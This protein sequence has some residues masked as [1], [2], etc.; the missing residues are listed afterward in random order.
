MRTGCVVWPAELWGTSHDSQQPNSLV[1]APCLECRWK[2]NLI[3]I[4]V[5][6]NHPYKLTTAR[7]RTLFNICLFFNP[8]FLFCFVFK[9]HVCFPI[10]VLASF[11]LPSFYVFLDRGAVSAHCLVAISHQCLDPGFLHVFHSLKVAN[12]PS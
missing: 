11:S 6:S 8:V 4:Q 12:M 5:Q 7:L 10:Q 9:A 1:W 2:R 3:C